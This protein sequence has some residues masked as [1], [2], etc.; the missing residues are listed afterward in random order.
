MPLT[1]RRSVAPSP[2]PPDEAASDAPTCRVCYEGS[3]RDAG[4]LLSACRC[5]G[6]L[7]H[8]HSR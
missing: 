4:P 7:A 5:K 6:G 8:I 1:P 3:S 2:P